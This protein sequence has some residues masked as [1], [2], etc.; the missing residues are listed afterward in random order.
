MQKQRI[1]IMG[2]TFDPIHHG[3]LVTAETARETYCLD[4]VV[5]IPSARPPHKQPGSVSDFW[6]RYLMVLLAV[7]SHPCFRVSKIEYE[8]TGPSYTIDTIRY[9]RR[10]HNK[11]VEFFFITGADAILE[12]VH[13][14]QPEE[15]LASCRFIAATR[16][17]Y[18]LE[19]NKT[20]LGED[21][22]RAVSLLEVP[23]LSISSSELSPFSI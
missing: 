3:H 18:D 17:G 13:W 12:I 21:F 6:H 11:G 7:N 1:G 2:G 10:R 4:E 15:L 23:L 5:F 22:A 19:K 14:K 20:L 16:P 8:R 9:F